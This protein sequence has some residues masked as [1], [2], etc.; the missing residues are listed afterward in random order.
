VWI[1]RACT[2]NEGPII[3]HWR[4]LADSTGV[5]FLERTAGGNQRLVLADLRKKTV[6]PLTRRT[7]TIKSFDVRDRKHY[8]YTVSD[9]DER[10]K[11]QTEREGP[12][13]VG[14]GRS[15]YELL[16]PD[17]PITR[18][19]SSSRSY[20]NLN[21]WA[22]VNGKSFRVNSDT[23]LL[24]LIGDRLAL[25][26]K[27]SSLIAELPTIQSGTPIR[28]DRSANGLRARLNRLAGQ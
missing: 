1:V 13:V 22:V 11:S 24:S 6:E 27:G 10:A 14:T 8:V 7:D 26:P 20:R 4:W 5:A 28:P 25:S 15:L 16:L 12:T 19:V 23:A 2:A 9:P 21:L 17:N 3:G 18:A